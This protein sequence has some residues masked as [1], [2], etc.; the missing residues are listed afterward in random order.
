MMGTDWQTYA[1][2]AIVTLTVAV[3]LI[4]LA[5]GGRGGCGGSCGCPKQTAASREPTKRSP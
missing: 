3:F 2:G 1:A 5:R 4:R